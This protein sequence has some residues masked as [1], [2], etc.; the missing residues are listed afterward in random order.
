MKTREQ[1]RDWALEQTT[2]EPALTKEHLLKHVPSNP[3]ERQAFFSGMEDALDVLA[4]S[5]KIAHRGEPEP[6]TNPGEQVMSTPTLDTL[7]KAV[8]TSGTG[9]KIN[10]KKP[11]EM[12]RKDCAVGLHTKTGQPVAYE[13]RQVMTAPEVALA[14]I[15]VWVKHYLRS[16]NNPTILGAMGLPVP[17]M[18]EHE[19]LLLAETLTESRFCG[20]KADNQ[21]SNGATLAELGLH[22]K[23][24]LNDATSGGQNLVPYEFDD[25]VI[26]YALL[27]GELLPFVDLKETGRDEVRTSDIA[28]PTVYWGAGE[29]SSMPVFNTDSMIDP[30]SA[31][32]YPVTCALT[33]GRD[34]ASDSPVALGAILQQQ[35]GQVMLKELDHVIANGVNASSQPEGLF[36]KEGATAVD[37]ENAAAG[38]PTLA[39]YQSL[40]FALPKQYR[41][42]A[43]NPCFVSNDTVYQRSRSIKIDPNDTTTDQRPVFGLE[44]VN[45]YQTLEWPHRIQND[46]ANTKLA[47]VCLKLYRM[48]RRTGFEFRLVT[49][50]KSLALKNENLLIC[51]GRYAGLLTDVNACAVMSDCQS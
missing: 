42:R 30:V 17:Q 32:V 46:I 43:L 5:L 1:W 18:T 23:S 41:L 6:E 12:Y 31:N 45:S 7:H 24:L 34:L 47:F 14:K 50:G 33:Y 44:A 19:R 49:E 22:A 2:R 40:M 26:T 13:G 20:L 27:H 9:G 11:S 21:W 15:G 28:N 4:L 3:V 39:D 8:D 16:G 10:V 35:I 38:P 51:R 29:G 48:W 25:A 37:S 36:S